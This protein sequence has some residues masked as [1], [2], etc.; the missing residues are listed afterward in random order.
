MEIILLLSSVFYY[1]FSMIYKAAPAWTFKAKCNFLFT[2]LK[3]Q[4]KNYRLPL[5][6]IN[7]PLRQLSPKHPHG[8]IFV[9]TQDG[10]R[11][12]KSAK[13]LE[14]SESNHIQPSKQSKNE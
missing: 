14:K 11:A 13:M 10:K 12:S 7:Q 1:H 2:Q 6:L 9:D 4:R 8:S 5:A 3:H